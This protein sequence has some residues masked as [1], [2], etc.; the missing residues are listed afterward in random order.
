[1]HTFGALWTLEKI[2]QTMPCIL[3][4]YKFAYASSIRSHIKQLREKAVL[5]VPRIMQIHRVAGKYFELDLRRLPNMICP[6]VWQYFN[7]C[8][9]QKLYAHTKYE[10]KWLMD[11]A[12]NRR[13]S[14]Y[15]SMCLSPE[16]WLCLLLNIRICNVYIYIRMT[17]TLVMPTHFRLVARPRHFY[18]FCSNS[19]FNY[20]LPGA[21]AA[22]FACLCYPLSLF[23]GPQLTCDD[24]IEKKKTGQDTH[25]TIASIVYLRYD[26]AEWNADCIY[27]ITV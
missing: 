1:M 8:L 17:R 7:Q 26:M 6:N 10:S 25:A 24:P 27:F 5:F 2:C 3:H 19:D 4:A 11:L 13:Q 23:I 22:M 20:S 15:L 21:P 9:S 18:L 14:V 16:A 12:S